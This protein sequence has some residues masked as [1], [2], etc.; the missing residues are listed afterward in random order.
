MFQLVIDIPFLT[1]LRVIRGDTRSSTW[2]AL[3]T[4]GAELRSGNPS[5]APP[6]DGAGHRVRGQMT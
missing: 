5:R 2:S 1:Q 4:M 3:T 6:D